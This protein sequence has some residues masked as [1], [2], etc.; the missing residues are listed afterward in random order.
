MRTLRHPVAPEVCWDTRVERGT[1]VLAVSGEGEYTAVF[2][3]MSGIQGV[4]VIII[5][6]HNVTAYK[7]FSVLA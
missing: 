1:A 6:K 2:A 5:V 3:W 7:I 4:T